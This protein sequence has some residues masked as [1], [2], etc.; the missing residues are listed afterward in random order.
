MH[1]LVCAGLVSA[2]LSDEM[3]ITTTPSS[4]SRTVLTIATTGWTE[5][6]TVQ[7]TSR[8]ETEND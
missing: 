5:K 7:M 6:N 3:N 2:V 1:V 8:Q 4:S